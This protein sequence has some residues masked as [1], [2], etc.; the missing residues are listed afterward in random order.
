M[1]PVQRFACSLTRLMPGTQSQGRAAFMQPLGTIKNKKGHHLNTPPLW[2]TSRAQHCQ[3][4]RYSWAM[5]NMTAQELLAA[6]AA[7]ERNF[8]QADLS[9]ADLGHANLS[10]A[11]FYEANLREAVLIGANLSGADLSFAKLHN[12]D[13]WEANLEGANLWEANLSGAVLGRA[14]LRNTYLEGVDFDGAMLDGA[15]FEGATTIR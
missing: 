11:K 15:N 9:G 4:K 8:R 14:N 6:Y 3:A 5:E 1:K 2:E 10:G 13:L 12:A 7:G